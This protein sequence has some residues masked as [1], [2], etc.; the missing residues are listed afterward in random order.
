MDV[1]WRCDGGSGCL[2]AWVTMAV[3]LRPDAVLLSLQRTPV[4]TKITLL[5]A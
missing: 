1:L 3:N 5:K 4:A 2:L